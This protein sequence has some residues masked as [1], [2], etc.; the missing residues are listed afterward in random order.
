MDMMQA[1]ARCGA[2]FQCGMA[3]DAADAAGPCWC[4]ALPHAAALPPLPDGTDADVDATMAG[5]W[6]RACLEQ[7][8]AHRAA[9][10]SGSHDPG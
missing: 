3:A 2:G 7:H 4:M 9:A 5:C 10:A 1:C 6:C 8:I